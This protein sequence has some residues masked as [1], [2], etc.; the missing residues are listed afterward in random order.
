MFERRHNRNSNKSSPEPRCI[1][2][3]SQCPVDLSRDRRHA[4][5][6]MGNIVI[7]IVRALP[8]G[9]HSRPPP[10]GDGQY[11]YRSVLYGPARSTPI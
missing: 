11:R 5:E 10:S 7:R 3:P 2:A 1:S 9:R 4:A 6:C 8:Q